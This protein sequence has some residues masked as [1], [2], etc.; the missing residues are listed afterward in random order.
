MKGIEKALL[1]IVVAVALA[2]VISDLSTPHYT[3]SG[4]E[5]TQEEYSQNPTNFHGIDLT[6]DVS[7]VEVGKGY[8]VAPPNYLT[9]TNAEDEQFLS[10][11]K[12]GD[13][14]YFNPSA[15]RWEK[16]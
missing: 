6:K 3:K 10:S 12:V 11:L 5:Y 9:P 15:D 4:P 1:V 13:K 7:V 2:F 16:R 14:I 8:V